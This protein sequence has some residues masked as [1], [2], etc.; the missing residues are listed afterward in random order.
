MTEIDALNRDFV[1]YDQVEKSHTYRL[2]EN[3][4]DEF[5]EDYEIATLDFGQY[6]NGD[7]AD[8]VQVKSE[9][10]RARLLDGVSV[11]AAAYGYSRPSSTW[12]RRA[13]SRPG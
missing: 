11:T 6:L 12:S 8:K 2:A 13:S 9:M 5:D 3:P 10:L 4:G 7:A 1:K